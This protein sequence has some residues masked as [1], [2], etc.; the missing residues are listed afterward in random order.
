[1]CQS[2]TIYDIK[3]EKY[4]IRGPVT[5]LSTYPKAKCTGKWANYSKHASKNTL[6]FQINYSYYTQITFSHKFHTTPH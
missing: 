4:P 2:Y 5:L 3:A 6:F 1:M